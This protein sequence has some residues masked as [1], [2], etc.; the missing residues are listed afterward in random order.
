MCN[1]FKNK[2]QIG[3]GIPVADSA[4]GHRAS[5]DSSQEALAAGVLSLTLWGIR[6]SIWYGLFICKTDFKSDFPPSKSTHE[7]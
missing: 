3:Q 7:D 5:P 6:Q 1:Q 4:A 2:T